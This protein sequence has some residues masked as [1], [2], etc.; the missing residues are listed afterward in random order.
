MPPITAAVVVISE[1]DLVTIV[2]GPADHVYR[3]VAAP[4]PFRSTFKLQD[5]V[6]GTVLAGFTAGQLVLAAR[7][8][9]DE[10]LA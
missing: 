2:H 8:V 4:G 10:V 3:V 6:C 5:V 7:A 1:C 9:D